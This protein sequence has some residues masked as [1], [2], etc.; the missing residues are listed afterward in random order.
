MTGP[1]PVS[2]SDI[3]A[4]AA[5]DPGLTICTVSFESAPWL[6]LNRALVERL[7]PGKTPRWLVAE[8][9]PAGSAHRLSPAD[10]DF[11][12][13][14]G[15][16]YPARAFAAASYHHAAGL[17]I[18]ISRVTSRYL[19]VLDPDFFIIRRNWIDELIAHM[20]AAGIAIL[21]AP[22][23]PARINKIRY[24][25]CAHC[26]LIDL[27]QVPKDSLDFSPGYERVPDWA[28]EKNKQ[29]SRIGSV[30]R[31]LSLARRRR[32]GTSRDTGWRLARRYGD[33]T[34]A[35]VECLLPVFQPPAGRRIADW[36][37]PDRLSFTPKRK[38][39]FT[40]TG[41]EAYGLPD[42]R[43]RGWEEFIWSGAPFGFHVRCQPIRNKQ[44]T[45]LEEHYRFAESVL[46]QV[47][48]GIS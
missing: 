34:S 2:G 31:R 27:R 32:I 25:P 17:G 23:H 45:T 22:W 47:W 6:S 38:G 7:N 35:A 41:F 11:E 5:A 16:P 33:G 8:N 26:T 4:S 48:S 42:L 37:F 9:S 12:V 18:A 20:R 30:M 39:C 19:L 36:F 15:T 10:R 21:G 44:A 28:V 43:S 1:D 24:F 14:E 46:E 13:L 3:P 29:H 40:R